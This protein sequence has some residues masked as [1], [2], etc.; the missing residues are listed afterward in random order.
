MLPHL[1]VELLPSGQLRK[2]RPEVALRIA[3]RSSVAE[4]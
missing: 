2:G 4:R 3:G 1:A